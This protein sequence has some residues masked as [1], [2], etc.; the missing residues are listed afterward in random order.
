MKNTKSTKDQ[1]RSSLAE[2]TLVEWMGDTW[3]VQTLDGES[4]TLE[5][6]DGLGITVNA[7]AREVAPLRQ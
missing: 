2:G 5:D 7:W 4:I 1:G 6:R 3:R